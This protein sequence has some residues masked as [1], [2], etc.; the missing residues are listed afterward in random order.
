MFVASVAGGGRVP[1]KVGGPWLR[2]IDGTLI[3]ALLAAIVSGALWLSLFRSQLEQALAD[4]ETQVTMWSVVTDTQFGRVSALRFLIAL[5]L[6]GLCSV[7]YARPLPRSRSLGL[8]RRA[9]RPRSRREPCLVRPCRQRHGRWR[10]RPSR[11]R[12]GPS[13]RGG[14]LGR[15]SYP[16]APPPPAKFAAHASRAIRHGPALLDSC[17]V[18]RRAVG[19]ERSRQ[20]LVHDQRLPRPD[21]NRLWRPPPGQGR[22]VCSHAG[23]R[24]LEPIPIDPAPCWRRAPP[25]L[26]RCGGRLRRNS[27][28]DFSSFGWWRCSARRSR[29][30][31]CMSASPRRVPCSPKTRAAFAAWRAARLT[32]MCH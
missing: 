31:T 1:R 14:D 5:L 4:D 22:A 28:S 10:R 8:A 26:K 29:P 16:L 30:A 13:R 17:R 32:G 7:R 23:L 20:H 15:R 24:R 9:A 27:R 25:P 2:E 18:E 3:A 11:G 6:I 21:R 19:L 12:C